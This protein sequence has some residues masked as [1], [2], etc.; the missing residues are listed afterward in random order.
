MEERASGVSASLN[1]LYSLSP[2]Q[3]LGHLPVSTDPSAMLEALYLL[4]PLCGPNFSEL[5]MQ[6]NSAI[7]SNGPSQS[8]PLSR[9]VYV[10]NHS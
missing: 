4:R 10:T 2:R 9:A 8:D 7:T 1:Y 6:D 3:C 5:S